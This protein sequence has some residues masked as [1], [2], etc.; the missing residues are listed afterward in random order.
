MKVLAL[1]AVGQH[2]A[3]RS[4]RNVF[5]A[6]LEKTPAIPAAAMAGVRATGIHIMVLAK[7]ARSCSS[8]ISTPVISRTDA[9]QARQAPLEATVADVAAADGRCR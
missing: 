1:Q 7:L 4:G 3:E 6:R 8:Q 2:N 5:A 9:G